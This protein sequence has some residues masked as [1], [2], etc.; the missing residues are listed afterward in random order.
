MA[1]TKDATPN[2]GEE[3]LIEELP[4]DA[5]I[6]KD[7]SALHA[8]Q[9][10]KGEYSYYFA[11]KGPKEL[12]EDATIREADP[13]KTA[14]GQGPKKVE[15]ANN[16]IVMDNVK[17]INNFAFCDEEMVVKMYIEF[18]EDIKGAD[19]TCEWERFGVELL[20]KCKTGS[21]YGVRIRDAEGWILE[22]ERKN[23]FAHEIVPEKCKHRVSSSGPKITLTL[24]KKEKDTWYEL[25]K[26]DIKST[27]HNK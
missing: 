27:F 19:I 8:S 6:K 12:P 13:S 21:V 26:A 14:D 5:E 3:V 25:K 15:K 4:T 24:A 16:G 10:A 2:D 18:P 7:Q 9:E 1:D 22:H 11:H 17:W 20:V 23:G